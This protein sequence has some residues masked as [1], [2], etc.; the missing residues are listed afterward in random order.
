[1]PSTPHHADTPYTCRKNTLHV[2]AR[3]QL[4]L[5]TAPQCFWSGLELASQRHRVQAATSATLQRTVSNTPTDR[6]RA[7]GARGAWQQAAQGKLRGGGNA[8]GVRTARGRTF[9][10]A[11]HTAF[12]QVSG[13]NVTQGA[14]AARD[15]RAHDERHGR[16]SPVSAAT[17]PLADARTGRAEAPSIRGAKRGNSNGINTTEAQRS[18][19]KGRAPAPAGKGLST[20][21]RRPVYRAAVRRSYELH[22]KR[23]SSCTAL[24][25]A[26]VCEVASFVRRTHRQC[27]SHGRRCRL[28]A[29]VARRAA[30]VV[31][32]FV[33]GAVDSVFERSRSQRKQR[34]R[35]SHTQEQLLQPQ[36]RPSRSRS[37][38]RCSPHLQLPRAR[39]C[40]APGRRRKPRRATQPA[41]FR[42]APMRVRGAACQ[43]GSAA[44]PRAI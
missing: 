13:V 12:P 44:A 23:K 16:R 5:S 20:V 32:P 28:R 22:S 15:V 33:K 10:C 38:P 11:Q 17:A 43:A 37:C 40:R 2:A 14:L 30:H 31:M 35:Q 3:R 27:G 9:R 26:L 25:C 1:V 29:A 18:P 8:L 39:L 42:F 41:V 4:W 7:A 24:R 21:H 36:L 6:S 19:V 34:Q